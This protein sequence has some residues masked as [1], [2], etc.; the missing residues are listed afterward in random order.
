M[1]FS[2]VVFAIIRPS[3]GILQRQTLFFRATNDSPKHLLKVA[4]E[5]Q[6]PAA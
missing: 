4:R 2:E 5:T 3:H 6:R 1:E